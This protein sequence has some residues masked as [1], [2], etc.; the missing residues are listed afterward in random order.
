[1]SFLQ[2]LISTINKKHEDKRKKTYGGQ[3][4]LIKS[5]KSHQGIYFLRDRI[6]VKPPKSGMINSLVSSKRAAT[7]IKTIKKTTATKFLVKRKPEYA[8]KKAKPIKHDDE[9][10]QDEDLS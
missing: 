6:N 4:K 10:I 2:T 8:S 5:R 7:T 9:E 1:M 3:L